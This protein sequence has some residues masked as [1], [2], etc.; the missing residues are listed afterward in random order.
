MSVAA[1]RLVS[2]RDV[3]RLGGAAGLG[4]LLVPLLASCSDPN[5]SKLVFLNWQDYIDPTILSDF[6]DES[7]LSVTYETYASNDELQR[8]LVLAE[9]ARR[10]G[11]A[12]E[13]LRSHRPVREPARRSSGRSTASG[14]STR[15]IVVSLGNLAEEFR[16]EP[17]D[18]GNRFS[19][20]WATGTTGIGYDSTVFDGPPDWNVFLDPAH[21]GA[22]TILDETRD[23]FGAA[24]FAI[25]EDPNTSD[26]ATIDAAAHPDRRRAGP[27][28]CTSSKP[29]RST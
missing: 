3:L 1:P 2:R 17:F 8:R 9:T 24:L 22:M 12:G 27:N 19:V 16:R 5:E 18:P 6:S 14:S 21:Q 23:A 4:V 29:S 7:G 11:R 13:H 28:R 20:P 25:G 10:R 26:P 15:T